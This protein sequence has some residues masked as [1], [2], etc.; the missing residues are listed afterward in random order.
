[1]KAFTYYNPVKIYFGVGAIENLKQELT[2]CGEKIL[3]TYGGGSI[4]KNGIYEQVS[5]ILKEAGKTVFELSGIMANPRTDK[6]M[7][8]VEIC[9][10][11]KID[12]I[13][14]AGGGSVI[15]CSKAIATVS[16]MEDP[17][18]FW[19][20]LFVNKEKTDQAIPLGT[21]LTIPATGSEM[22]TDC[23]ITNWEEQ[24]KYSYSSIHQ[25]PR[26]SILDPEYTYTMPKN[27]LIYGSVD[28]L[29]HIFEIYFS[30]PDENNVSDDV[31]EALMRNVMENLDTA[32]QDPLDENARS[33]LMWDSTMALNGIIQAGK[34]EDWMAHKIEHALSAFYD[35][36]H[37]AG[38]AICHPA[39]L[40]YI[41]H[42]APGK[43]ARY[44]VRVMGCDPKGKTNEELAEEGI[45]KT[46][47]YFKKIG[48]PVTLSQ[49]GIPAGAIEKIVEKIL[50]IPASYTTLD[51]EDLKKILNSC[52]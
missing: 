6:V 28:I 5:G 47:E 46:R 50:L 41:C 52:I 49:V 9:R 34:E 24:L 23:V 19:N 25:Y 4:K 44:A 15:D 42:K 1:M 14:A 40:S 12:F 10:R 17:A 45:R 8:G 30:K 32:L 3:L 37:G 16:C 11:E 35:I 39:Y 48:A 22:N 31:A 2:D 21:I 51:R 29:S 27:Q 26:F 13:L 43:F 33:N 20:R 18:D 38:L 7:E 36:P